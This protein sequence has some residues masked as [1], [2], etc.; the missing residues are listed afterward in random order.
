MH[1]CR[2]SVLI[3]LHT[4]ESVQSAAWHVV[5]R[6]M[7]LALLLHWHEANGRFLEVVITLGLLVTQNQRQ[8]PS[9]ALSAER[10]G[11]RH[12]GRAIWRHRRTDIASVLEFR[13]VN[14]RHIGGGTV[15]EFRIVNGRY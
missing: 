11:D 1:W 7:I 13:T 6:E 9:Q 14:V 10:Y 4:F 2:E 15:L 12:S 3:V 8:Q 5:M